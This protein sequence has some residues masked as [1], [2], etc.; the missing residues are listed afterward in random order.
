MDFHF[1]SAPLF[2]AIV[3]DLFIY[4]GNLCGCFTAKFPFCLIVP[5]GGGFLHYATFLV[6]TV[7]KKVFPHALVV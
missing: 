2:C 3:K 6:G 1:S 5:L 4:F 7:G